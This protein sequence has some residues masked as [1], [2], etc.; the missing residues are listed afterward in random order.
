MP[1]SWFFWEKSPQTSNTVITFD[2][3]LIKKRRAHDRGSSFCVCFV[4]S[5]HL[6][7]YT[8]L[9]HSP[10]ASP[11]T[12]KSKWQGCH[13]R[14]RTLGPKLSKKKKFFFFFSNY[15]NFGG[16]GAVVGCWGKDGFLEKSAKLG[17]WSYLSVTL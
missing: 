3:L 11:A 4:S 10:K 9:S 13:K 2:N 14:V 17:E 12:K 16:R 8:Y 15:P 7:T 1:K 5:K 6:S